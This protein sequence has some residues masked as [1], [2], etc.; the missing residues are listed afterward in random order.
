MSKKKKGKGHPPHHAAPSP[1]QPHAAP[2][3]PQPPTRVTAPATTP[4]AER[5]ASLPTTLPRPDLS[6]W[7]LAGV[8]GLMLATLLREFAH[9]VALRAAGVTSARLLPTAVR[10]D[11]QQQFWAAIE[12]RDFP[13]A[14]AFAPPLGIGWAELSV[15]FITV[16]LTWGA[17]LLVR[18]ED[19]RPWMAGIGLAAPLRL[20][21]PAAYVALVVLRYWQ[22]RPPHRQPELAEYGVELLLGLPAAFLLLV[23]IVLCVPAVRLIFDACQFST[24]RIRAIAMAAGLCFGVAVLA[25]IAG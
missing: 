5:Q 20:F 19:L 21:A 18:R 12:A 16:A 23:E 9:F 8:I 17:A 1:A 3:R 10:F 24:E 14:A 4:P 13:G 6:L 11:N 7:M 15:P 2:P 25:A 22:G